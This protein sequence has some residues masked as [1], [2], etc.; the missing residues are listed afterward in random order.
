VI[1]TDIEGGT[2]ETVR[3]AGEQGRPVACIAGYR[4]KHAQLKSYSGN[5][6]LIEEGIAVPIQNRE[7]LDRFL[8]YCEQVRFYV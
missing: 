3:F 4:G 2:M 8:S 1:E 6:K 5:K 7:D